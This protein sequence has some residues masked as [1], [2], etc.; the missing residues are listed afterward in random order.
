MQITGNPITAAMSVFLE[1][2]EEFRKSFRLKRNVL[3]TLEQ[4]TSLKI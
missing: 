1:K 3:R 4:L 2:E